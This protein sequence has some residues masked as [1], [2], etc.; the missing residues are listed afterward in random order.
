MPQN[1]ETASEKQFL[2]VI[3]WYLL[4]KNEHIQVSAVP[5][6]LYQSKGRSRRTEQS[7]LSK[8][9]DKS[10]SVRVVTYPVSRFTDMSLWRIKT[11][12]E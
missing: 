1:L 6:L 4:V 11:V 2:I 9:A 5:D 12:K 10:N 8:A 3:D 7:M